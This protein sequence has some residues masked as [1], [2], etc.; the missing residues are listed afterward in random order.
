MFPTVARTF[1]QMF[2]I[3]MVVMVGLDMVTCLVDEVQQMS[4]SQWVGTPSIVLTK[5]SVAMAVVTVSAVSSLRFEGWLGWLVAC[6]YE[7]ISLRYGCCGPIVAATR[8]DVA[9]VAQIRPSRRPEGWCV[10][11]LPISRRSK[12]ALSGS[13]GPVR[14]AR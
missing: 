1:L 13:T 10:V 12:A 9:K 14:T 6:L 7:R 3:R 11:R 2:I 4:E 5:L 8:F